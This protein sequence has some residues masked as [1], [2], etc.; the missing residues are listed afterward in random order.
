MRRQPRGLIPKHL[1]HESDYGVHH[2]QPLL[3]QSAPL[4]LVVTALG[5]GVVYPA[6]RVADV[7]GVV[8]QAVDINL[9]LQFAEIVWGLDQLLPSIP[10]IAHMATSGD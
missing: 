9:L 8:F 3:V 10:N 7:A 4:T 2:F 1:W 6:D 5:E